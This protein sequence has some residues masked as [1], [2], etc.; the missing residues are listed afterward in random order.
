MS[1]QHIAVVDF[2]SH[3]TRLLIVQDTEPERVIVFACEKSEGV[4]H[5]VIVD[6]EK[7]SYMLKRLLDQVKHKLD[8]R[9]SSVYCS[10][11]GESI[12]S[13]S[14]HGVV[15]IR[16]QEVSRYDMED[17]FA[18]AE[19]ISLDNQKVIHLVPKQYKV[20]NQVGIKD[21]LGMY[22]IRL[23]GDFHLVLVDQGVSQ[24]MTRCF[25]RVGIQVEG[26]IF[27]PLGLADAV[28]YQDE[29]QQGIILVDMGEGTTDYVVCHDG[30]IKYSGSI[31]IGGG[32]VTRDIAHKLKVD[33]ATAEKLK[34]AVMKMQENAWFEEGTSVEEIQSVISA[35]YMQI[36]K[37]IEQNIIREGLK[38][39]IDRGVVLCGGASQY[40]NLSELV[41]SGLSYPCR[42]GG[43]IEDGIELKGQSWLG[44]IGLVFF[45]RQMGA[46]SVISRNNPCRKAFK[47]LQ[48]WLEVYF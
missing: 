31:P 42:M 22:G 21:P 30:V 36:F 28:L 14:S 40:P 46:N 17:L 38:K 19:A 39:Y 44:T 27:K 4:E 24:N 41:E 8:Y 5:G 13:V 45:V 23:E 15:K 9:I 10:I 32:A 25:S 26:F 48:R 47:M 20:D 35:R 3:L 43:L 37:L 33:N 18:T 12:A 2:G 7:A 6:L 16:H 11:S 34:L 1:A 29:K